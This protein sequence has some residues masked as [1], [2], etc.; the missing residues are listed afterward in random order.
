MEDRKKSS[1]SN[2]VIDFKSGNRGEGGVQSKFGHFKPD[3][4]LIQSTGRIKNQRDVILS[5]L[6]K[7]QESRNRVSPTVY[8][9]VNRDYA[10]QLETIG[11]LLA[12]KQD[13]L[14]EAKSWKSLRVSMSISTSSQK[15]AK[16]WIMLILKKTWKQNPWVLSIVIS[17]H[18]T[19]FSP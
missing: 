12:E 3:D 4:E 1:T 15:Y 2:N 10:L 16:G 9:K 13:Y 11:E 8:E 18:K 17:H 5:R 19:F 7:M 14:S 6:Q